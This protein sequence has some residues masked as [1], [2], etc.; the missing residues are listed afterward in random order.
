MRREGVRVIAPALLAL[1]TLLASPGCKP[2]AFA[3][4]EANLL[5]EPPPLLPTDVNAYWNDT[6]GETYG[7]L[8]VGPGTYLYGGVPCRTARVTSISTTTGQH[9]DQTLLYCPGQDGQVHLDRDLTCRAAAEGAVA[10]R[11]P[12]GDDVTL[13]PG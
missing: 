6:A 7:E 5:R 4:H 13:R 10:C 2:T 3:S 8:T 11:T 9:E 1:A 12:D